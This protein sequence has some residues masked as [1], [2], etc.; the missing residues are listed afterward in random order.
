MSAIMRH[1]TPPGC[2]VTA[3]LCQKA[4]MMK[5]LVVDDDL[6]T[7]DVMVM[8]LNEQGFDLVFPASSGLDAL[9]CLNDQPDIEIIFCDL[10]MP[11]M[12][13][14]NWFATWH[15]ASFRAESSC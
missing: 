1:Q 3:G 8:S 2:F 4:L 5:M 11:G 6:F 9:Q 14:V 12:D 7:L 10:K 15:A 13:G